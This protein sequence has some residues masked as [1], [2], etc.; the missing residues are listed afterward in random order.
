MGLCIRQATAGEL[1]RWIGPQM[2]EVVGVLEA[3]ARSRTRGRG[4]YRQGLHHFCVASCLLPHTV[5]RRPS[6]DAAR[7]IA[8]HHAPIQRSA[9]RHQGAAVTFLA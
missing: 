9:A 4:T 5:N 1:E 6:R 7:S 3:A 2:I 8:S